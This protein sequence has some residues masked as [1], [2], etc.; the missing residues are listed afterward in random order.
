MWPKRTST[1]TWKAFTVIMKPTVGVNEAVKNW[2]AGTLH[3]A[4]PT[5]PANICEGGDKQI[6]P[7]PN[8]KFAVFSEFKDSMILTR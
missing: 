7:I 1:S 4:T 8:T 3:S 5:K 2:T 6:C